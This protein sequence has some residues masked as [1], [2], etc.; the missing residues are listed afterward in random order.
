MTHLGSR[1]SVFLL[2]QNLTKKALEDVIFISR[3]GFAVGIPSGN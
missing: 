1:A 3:D 2:F